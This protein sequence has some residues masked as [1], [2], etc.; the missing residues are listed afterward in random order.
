MFFFNR[1]DVAQYVLH[2]SRKRIIDSQSRSK[3]FCNFPLRY[4]LSFQ[5][6]LAIKLTCVSKV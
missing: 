3:K 6:S 4:C 5:K 2:Q 1:S